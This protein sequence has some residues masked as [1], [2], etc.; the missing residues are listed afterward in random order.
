MRGGEWIK[1]DLWRPNTEI[2]AHKNAGW[3]CTHSNRK[4]N[5]VECR[6][7]GGKWAS[8]VNKSYSQERPEHEDTQREALSFLIVLWWEPK[9]IN[10]RPRNLAWRAEDK[11]IPL[12]WKTVKS[13][14][15]RRNAKAVCEQERFSGS[16]SVP[17]RTEAQK[18]PSGPSLSPSHGL[19]HS[20]YGIS[21]LLWS[22]QEGGEHSL[23]HLM[24]LLSSSPQS[25]LSQNPSPKTQG[26]QD[27]EDQGAQWFKLCFVW[28]WLPWLVKPGSI[29]QV[30]DA[31]KCLEKVS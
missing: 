8:G 6:F 17:W 29:K 25:H 31:R 19:P 9:Q 5:C 4:V 20:C 15:R 26:S 2:S 18:C 12:A 10:Q 21:W 3:R 11:N 13:P 16:K 30:N 24:S 23:D 27:A 1:S 7:R 28:K 14:V 22:L